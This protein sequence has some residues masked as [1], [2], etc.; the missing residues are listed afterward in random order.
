MSSSH[1]DT[2]LLLTNTLERTKIPQI[3]PAPAEAIDA[4]RAFIRESASSPHPVLLVPDRDA[5][6]LS[7]GTILS[8]T[9]Q[10]L[11][12]PRDKILTSFVPGGTSIFTAESRQLLTTVCKARNVSH[13][14]V[15]DQGSRASPPLVGTDAKTLIVDHHAATSFPEGAAVVNAC[16]HP[17][18]ATS[19]LLTYV[20]C[21]PLHA[22]VSAK[23]AWLALMGIVGDL[24]SRAPLGPP[25][26]AELAAAKKGN[27]AHLGK[28]VPLLNAPRR[29]P[30]SN[31]LDAWELLQHAPSE[32]VAPRDLLSPA[33]AEK[34]RLLGKLRDAS[35][36]V[37]TE[38]LRCGR[39]PPRFSRDGRVAVLYL[40]SAYQVHPVVATRWAGML[41]SRKLEFVMAANGGYVPGKVNFSC[42]IVK[43]KRE[44]GEVDIIRSLKGYAA[45]DPW[46]AE[47]IGEDFA[48]GHREASGGSLEKDVWAAF[49]EKG[50]EVGVKEEVPEGEKKS[51]RKGKK[52]V[53]RQ[54]NTLDTCVGKV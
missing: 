20:I 25:Y 1:P 10:L 32:E 30:E 12:K 48:R 5:D 17:P 47:N 29:T 27:T 14:I 50:L 45:R 2:L 37:R 18:I 49:C 52:E 41:N 42:R 13:V 16:N 43:G 53:K 3:W 35:A 38:T 39:V 36:R 24:S 26:P 9:L 22:A 46:L 54:K 44:N 21:K 33:T 8:L 51:P 31:T 19:S 6:G 23:T 40:E 11:S 7:S 15:L 34:Q 4:A 28:L